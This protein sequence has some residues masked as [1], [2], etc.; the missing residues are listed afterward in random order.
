M[1][2]DTETAATTTEA[3]APEPVEKKKKKAPAKKKGTK[4]VAK[5]KAK[6]KANAGNGKRRYDEER[7]DTHAAVLRVNEG[8]GRAKIIEKLAN[9]KGTLFTP[10]ALAKIAG[11]DWDKGKVQHFVTQRIPFKAKKYGKTAEFKVV[12]EDGKYGLAK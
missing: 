3:V 1:K 2:D 4:P 11:E 6:R 12:S 10:E 8:T 9:N 5:K 7:K